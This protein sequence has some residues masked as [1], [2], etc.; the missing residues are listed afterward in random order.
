VSTNLDIKNFEF[1]GGLKKTSLILI[2]I[3][4]IATVCGFLMN[5]TIA[6][7]DFIVNNVYFVTIAVSGVFFLA[8]TGV[9]QASWITPYKRIPE[10]MTK[11]LPYGAVLMLL[12]YFGLHSVYEWTHTELVAND[13]ILSQKTA[14]LNESFYMIRMV[15]IFAAWI[16]VGMRLTKLSLRQDE[17]HDVADKIIGSS[18][19]GLVLFAIGISVASFDWLMS[20]EP[21]WFSTIYGVNVFA[22]SFVAGMSFICLATIFLKERGYF[23]GIINENHLHDMGKWM[24]GFSTFWAYTWL[25]QFLLIWYANIPEETEYYVLRFDHWQFQWA[26]NLILNWGAPFLLLMSRPAKRNMKRLK[27]VAIILL[28]GHFLDLYLML[29]PKVFEHNDIHSL[30]SSG[31]GALQ[32]AQWL[33]F[34]GLFIFV[35][36]SAFSKRDIIAKGDPQLEEGIHLHQ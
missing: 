8:I 10:A 20:V 17:G 2:V 4:I 29:A 21:H 31:F 32:L 1:K 13:P 34:A 27:L 23:K 3:G 19:L 18:A 7:V 11:F 22:G 35:V 12:T 36:G 6:W 14:W 9:L 30:A 33:G 24:F 28:V 15:L 16:F 25:S 26:L 5:P